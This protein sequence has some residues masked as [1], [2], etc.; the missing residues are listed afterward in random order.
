MSCM[1]VE[2]LECVLSYCNWPAYPVPLSRIE[3]KFASP[4]VY[5]L[6]YKCMSLVLKHVTDD[7][8]LYSW[9]TDYCH[10]VMD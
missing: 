3:Q 8:R 5:I 9:D 1:Y 2:R 6:Y 7:G 10:T 4:P